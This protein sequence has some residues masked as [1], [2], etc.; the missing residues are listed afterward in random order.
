M[1]RVVHARPGFAFGLSLFSPTITAYEVGNGENL[2]GWYTGAGMTYLR[3][4]RD[5]C[6]NAHLAS[7]MLFSLN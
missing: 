5:S 1:A 4:G 2:K 6:G 7:K 3:D